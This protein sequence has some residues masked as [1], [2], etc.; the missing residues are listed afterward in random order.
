MTDAVF[1]SLLQFTDVSSCFCLYRHVVNLFPSFTFTK[2]CPSLRHSSSSSLFLLH[3]TRQKVIHHVANFVFHPPLKLVAQTE[4]SLY[5]EAVPTQQ[6]YMQQSNATPGPSTPSSGCLP[7]FPFQGRS[8]SIIH[9]VS[10][11]LFAFEWLERGNNSILTIIIFHQ[12]ILCQIRVI[13]KPCKSFQNVKL[14][15]L[16]KQITTYRLVLELSSGPHLQIDLA[17]TWLIESEL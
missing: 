4:P 14:Q 13:R 1:I 11:Q 17:K 2:A 12:I 7:L 16:A 10:L 6:F 5:T 9:Q 8:N 3:V 15:K